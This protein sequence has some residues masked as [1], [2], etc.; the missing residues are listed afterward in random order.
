MSKLVA[1]V[2]A[3]ISAAGVLVPVVAYA[4]GVKNGPCSV[5]VTCIGGQV[6]SCSGAQVCYW[7]GDASSSRG[8]VECD[9]Y[10]RTYCG[11]IE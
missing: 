10:G 8:F 6:V 3:A 11:L 5:S 1:F 2:V 4:Y 7:K 9:G